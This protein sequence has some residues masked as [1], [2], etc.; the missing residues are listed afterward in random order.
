M[1]WL[2]DA[3]PNMDKCPGW[4]RPSGNGEQGR[5]VGEEER[6]RKWRRR[7]KKDRMAIGLLA[8]VWIYLSLS[9]SILRAKVHLT[10][11][12]DSLLRGI[13]LSL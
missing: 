9:L 10:L 13:S 4:L 11:G 2:I 8:R 1:L 12:F 3:H 7:R 6:K 5:G